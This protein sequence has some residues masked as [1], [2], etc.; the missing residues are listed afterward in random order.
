MK[1]TNIPDQHTLSPFG[2]SDRSQRLP[3]MQ[4]ELNDALG[5]LGTIALMLTDAGVPDDMTIEQ[6]VARVIGERD[7]ARALGGAK[8]RVDDVTTRRMRSVTR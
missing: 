8:D 4:R 3:A 7:V 2:V 6:R 1:P 5:K